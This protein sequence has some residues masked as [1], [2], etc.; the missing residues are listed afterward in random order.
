MMKYIKRILTLVLAMTLSMSSITVHAEAEEISL[1][2]VANNEAIQ[3]EIQNYLEAKTT[4]PDAMPTNLSA[5]ESIEQLSILRAQ[6]LQELETRIDVCFDEVDVTSY[7]KDILEQDEDTLKL[8]VY[9]STLI[10]YSTLPDEECTDVMG[11]GT[12]HIMTLELNNGTYE[13]VADSFD[14]RMITGVCTEDILV[15]EA[16]IAMQQD[17]ICDEN[18]AELVVMDTN[19]LR[20][21]NY[22]VNSA[23]SYAHEWCG[24]STTLKDP[25]NGYKE[26]KDTDTGTIN[27]NS[28]YDSHE[29]V[30]CANFVSQCLF[31]GGLSE[32]STWYD[33]S[34]AWVNAAGLH[35]YLAGKG[36]S[37]V[38][39]SSGGSNIYPGNPV[40]WIIDRDGNVRTQ[41]DGTSSGHQ[42]ICTGYNSAGVPV[43]DAHS[44]NMYRIPYNFSGKTLR[45]ILITNSNQHIHS[46][47]YSQK[48]AA[49]HTAE[50][51]VCEERVNQTHTVV[52]SGNLQYCRQCGYTG[53][54]SGILSIEP[55]L[56]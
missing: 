5:E 7:I 36:Y 15:A 29:G 42:M 6:G 4:I 1:E 27:Y 38:L 24:V 40:C 44:Y 16:E 50:C 43:L 25:V 21:G 18:V 23:I 14:E 55:E 20:S 9:E 41:A 56:Q 49:Y 11:Y 46:Y 34:L 13:L 35:D 53:P 3:M 33:Q 31:A 45:T 32:D 28:A 8:K 26:N 22:N 47:S 12:D 17:S 52:T 48:N 37:S 39:V 10:S 30:D 51:G 19:N 54:F 2:A